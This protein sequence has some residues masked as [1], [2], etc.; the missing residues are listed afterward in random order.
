[1]NFQ[2]SDR[3]H[4]IETLATHVVDNMSVKDLEQYVYDQLE[5]NYNYM[6]MT[7]LVEFIDNLYGPEWFE[8][9][10]VE[11]YQLENP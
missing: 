10:K 9:N 3:D 6:T 1:M 4:L 8:Q 5:E 11:R 2:S 7:E